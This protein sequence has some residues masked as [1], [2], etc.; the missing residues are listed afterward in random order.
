MAKYNVKVGTWVSPDETTGSIQNVSKVP[1]EISATNEDNTGI[2]LTENQIVAFEGTVYVR[3]T[4]NKDAVF[5]TV[6]FKVNGKGGGGGGGGGTPYTLPTMSENIKGGAKVGS[7]LKMQG[8]KLNVDVQAVPTAKVTQTA[9]GATITLVDINGTTT[10]N[11]YNGI[12]GSNGRDGYSPTVAITNITNGH[13]V[14]ITDKSGT[15]NFNVLNGIN[16]ASGVSPSAS[17]SKTGDTATI[18][19]QDANGTTSAKIRDGAK[20]DKGDKGEDG[21]SFTIRAQY[22]TL[23]DLEAAHPTGTVGDAYLVGDPLDEEAPYLYMW[24][25]NT[26]THIYSWQNCGKIV[27]MKGDKGDKGDKGE[28]GVSPSITV[29][30]NP[31]GTHTITIVSAAGTSTTV[32]SN[33]ADGYSPTV[34]LTK[35]SGATYSTLSITDKNG[36]QTVTINDGKDGSSPT[37][38]IDESVVGQHKIT[39]TDSD[40][41]KH[42]TTIND[43]DKI[44]HWAANTQ[45]IVPQIVIY[46]D[47]L[48]EC[49]TAHTS[50]ANF[51]ISKWNELGSESVLVLENWATNTEYKTNQVVYYANSIYRCNNS[52][53]SSNISFETDIGNWDLVFSDLKNWQ[54]STYYQLDTVVVHDKFIYKCK[55]AHTSELTFTDIEKEKWD[56]IGG[57]VIATKAQIDALFI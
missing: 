39:F 49:K 34:S 8:D 9:S 12:N 3:G 50:G 48:Y 14:S 25:E 23:A 20:G 17:V 16:G 4:G 33:G 10:A 36:T 27:G 5:T 54:A 6:P 26:T 35:A 15:Q 30:D 7:G 40:G 19:I 44:A 41:T 43:G 29:V 57:S 13:K 51:D 31:N 55:L 53:T 32:I 47:C 56:I 11:V 46:D 45:Y 37:V 52:H 38:S 24:L 18:T 42:V 28:A 21:K 1:I 22:E 2:R